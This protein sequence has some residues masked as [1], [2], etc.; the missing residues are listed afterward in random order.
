MSQLP[1]KV[2]QSEGGG[3]VRSNGCSTPVS[4]YSGDSSYDVPHQWSCIS[5]S[6]AMFK[7]LIQISQPDNSLFYTPTPNSPHQA[8]HCYIQAHVDMF[9]VTLDKAALSLMMYSYVVSSTLNLAAFNC[10]TSKR[11]VVGDPL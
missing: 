10:G 9:C 4:V 11:L 8:I 2:F 6:T 5:T 3:G 7:I 1:V